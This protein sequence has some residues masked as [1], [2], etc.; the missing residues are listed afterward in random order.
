MEQKPKRRK[1]SKKQREAKRAAQAAIYE[2]GFNA[3]YEMGVRVTLVQVEKQ[4]RH[5][6]PIGG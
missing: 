3:G 4:C 2:E 6:C 1:L 5:N